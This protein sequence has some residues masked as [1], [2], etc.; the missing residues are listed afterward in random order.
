MPTFQAAA[1]EAMLDAVLALNGV[2][3]TIVSGNQSVGVTCFL[4][5]L[6]LTQFDNQNRPYRVGFQE[7]ITKTMLL[8][9]N[10]A[11]ETTRFEP[12]ESYRIIVTDTDAGVVRTFACV[13]PAGNEQ[14]S[15]AT[16][17]DRVGWRIHTILKSEDPITP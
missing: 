6:N 1:V 7:F 5:R 17:P 8:R 16:D 4:G 10:P 11:D 12:D 2:Q 13:S 15:R 14:P 3:V 9:W